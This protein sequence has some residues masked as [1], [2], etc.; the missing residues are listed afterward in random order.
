MKHTFVK[1]TNLYCALKARRCITRIVPETFV[2]GVDRVTVKVPE[3]VEIDGAL[4]I[5]SDGLDVELE[6]TTE[7]DKS[8]ERVTDTEEVTEA[9]A[10]VEKISV[11][12]VK[13]LVVVEVE[14]SADEDFDCARV[15]DTV[16]VACD[17]ECCVTSGVV[18]VIGD[19]S[20]DSLHIQWDSGQSPPLVQMLW[21][22]SFI[23]E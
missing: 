20:V 1:I 18:E 10:D 4:V 2:C 13:V 19:D 8:V 21:H 17:D 9:S 7:L 16:E 6:A 14:G 5:S 12:A 11:D 15:V 22:H 23:P 3:V